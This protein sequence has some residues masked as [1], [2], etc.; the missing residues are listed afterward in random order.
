MAAAVAG[1]CGEVCTQRERNALGVLLA[2]HTELS[3]FHAEYSRAWGCN[4]TQIADSC[5]DFPCLE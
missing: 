2:L 3:A 1:P 4:L 5:H